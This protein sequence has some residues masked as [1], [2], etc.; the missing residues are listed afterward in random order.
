MA[1]K[2]K[3]LPANAASSFQSLSRVQLFA[4][5]WTAACQ[6]SLSITNS[7]SP[8]KPCP[9][10]WWCHPT[11]LSSIV[12]FSSCPQS[13]PKWTSS[14]IIALT[15]LTLALPAP[16]CKDHCD[17]IEPIHII[18]GNFLTWRLFISPHLWNL[19]FHIR[20]PGSLVLE[21][22][23]WHLWWGEGETLLSSPY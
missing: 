10:S 8:P 2:V 13:F 22:G 5:P 18:Q 9:L 15:S 4:T 3:S 11:I 16:S 20:Q 14:S 23:L 7:W 19:S 21:L 12:P 1:Q 6:A 17:Y